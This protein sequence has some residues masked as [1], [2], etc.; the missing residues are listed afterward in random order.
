MSKSCEDGKDW[1]GNK[2]DDLGVISNKWNE[3]AD[4]VIIGSGF[5]GLTAAI[6]AKNAGASVIILEKMKGYGGNSII[7]D[8]MVAAAGT[9]FQKKERVQDSADL[10]YKDMVTAG[11]GL[12]HP[13]LARTVAENS[14]TIIQWTIDYLGVKYKDKLHHLGGHSIPR[15]HATH[16]YS[17]SA[18]I[19]RLIKKIKNL[20]MEVRGQMCLKK[21]LRDKE[22][23]V[24]G[25]LVR[26]G[27]N[28]PDPE[29]GIHRYI[30]AKKAVILATGGF[31]NDM[32]FRMT[33]DPRLTEEVDSTNKVSTTAEALIEA[34]RIGATPVHLSW[35]QLGPWTSPDE[36]GYGVGPYFADYVV[37]PF[38]I[39][40]N[41]TTGWRFVNELADRK[42]RADAILKTGQPCIG[43][44]DAIGVEQSGYKIEHCLKKGV[45]KKFDQLK[46]LSSG[47]GIPFDPLKETIEKYNRSVKENFD[48]EFR[49][50]I[51][52]GAHPLTL[53]PYY[54]IR[55]WPKVHHTMGGIQI[56]TRAQVM[57]L[58]QKPI[59]GLYAAGEVTGGIHGACRL[60]SCAITDCLVF[61]RIAGK[62]AASE[63]I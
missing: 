62:N 42:T 16:N 21:I 25:V 36:K 19:R 34:L 48:E 37:F 8:G 7:S 3:T 26:E 10:M 30:E 38:G 27:Y 60:G 46:E 18:I 17:G 15:S 29:S 4:V 14:N 32:S 12:N 50:P 40:V 31:A 39:M 2:R 45:V 23:R 22:G 52:P 49:K 61:G 9:P 44:A 20:G 41:Q 24:C 57:D 11:L 54:G 28:F 5:A 13:D 55:L 33:Q 43:I 47:Y 1:W 58:N 56:N 51:L 6:E 59:K 53:P 35:I 63:S